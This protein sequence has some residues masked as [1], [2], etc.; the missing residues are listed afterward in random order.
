MARNASIDGT[1]KTDTTQAHQNAKKIVIAPRKYFTSKN[2][3]HTFFIFLVLGTILNKNYGSGKLI[4]CL[5]FHTTPKLSTS[6]LHVGFFIE[7]SFFRVNC[8]PKPEQQYELYYYTQVILCSISSNKYRNLP[9][10]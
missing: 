4:E 6:S 10:S 8:F 1:I 9:V 3:P 2:S 5:I 7:Q